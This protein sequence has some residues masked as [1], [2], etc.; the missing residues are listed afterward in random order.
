MMRRLVLAL[1]VL[2]GLVVGSDGLARAQT[3][4]EIRLTVDAAPSLIGQ[5]D[6]R[7]LRDGV[8]VTDALCGPLESTDS[9]VVGEENPALMRRCID[10][11]VG[12][13]A[14]AMSGVAEGAMSGWRCGDF[15]VAGVQ[16]SDNL[17]VDADGGF[18]HWFCQGTVARP[19]VLIS[20]VPTTPPPEFELDIAFVDAAG[21]PF[22]PTCE[23]DV[24]YGQERRWCS[25]FDLD[26]EY[27]ATSATTPSGHRTSVDC[28]VLIEP[29]T[30]F[31]DSV[32]TFTLTADTPL[33]EC[34]RPYAFA[35]LTAV[36]SFF[37]VDGADPAWLDGVTIRVTGPDG[38]DVSSACLR[39]ER[40][41]ADSSFV[42]FDCLGLSD[43]SHSIEFGGVDDGLLV[44]SNDC[45]TFVVDDDPETS[46]CSYSVVDASLLDYP[47]F[48]DPDVNPA[49]RDPVESDDDVPADELP[50]TGPAPTGA[51]VP[52][53]LLLVAGGIMLA[54]G[55]RRTRLLGPG[56]CE[57]NV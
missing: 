42:E 20:P 43:G 21:D 1:V 28:L 44:E 17:I 8:D 9:D 12:V 53:A 24:Q 33:Y 37:G 38:G 26:A 2:T 36:V 35:P 30:T 10:P 47:P 40:F 41:A 25:G 49:D 39:R 34:D 14:V 56:R 27:S 45:A 29:T 55:R 50:V 23:T 54:V 11:P 3:P 15:L 48:E 31:G 16:A 4:N 22:V 18:G 5:L 32:D 7:L 19:G 51:L 6:P 57:H 52:A 13:Y 46:V